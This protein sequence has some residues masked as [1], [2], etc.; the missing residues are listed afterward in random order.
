MLAGFL[1]HTV[2]LG[3][4]WMRWGAGSRG[5]VLVWMDFPLSLLWLSA[6]GTRLLLFSLLAGGLWWA[7]LTGLLSSWVGQLSARR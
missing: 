3:L 4:V 7:L 2:A 1:F 5:L 6:Q